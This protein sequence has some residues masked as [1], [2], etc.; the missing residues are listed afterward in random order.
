[1][2]DRCYI[3]NPDRRQRVSYF[4]YTRPQDAAHPD[5]Q[6]RS[7]K[8]RRCHPTDGRRWLKPSS[9]THIPLCTRY[10]NRRLVLP[11]S[12][13]ARRSSYTDRHR[14]R[15]PRWPPAAPARLHRNAHHDRDTRA[16]AATTVHPAAAQRLAPRGAV[17]GD[18]DNGEQARAHDA[19]H[20][21]R[22][23]SIPECEHWW[24]GTYGDCSG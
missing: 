24:S 5:L 21:S 9:D 15:N 8:G 18:F 20:G 7:H 23:E 14:A 4:L 22:S 12:A 10:N 11:S 3:L 2:S 17:D 16:G 6:K 1:L 19:E 13:A